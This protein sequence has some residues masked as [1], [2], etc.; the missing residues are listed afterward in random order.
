MGVSDFHIMVSKK[1][2]L[3]KG[4]EIFVT[5]EKLQRG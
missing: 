3:E 5:L 1:V 4:D 2:F